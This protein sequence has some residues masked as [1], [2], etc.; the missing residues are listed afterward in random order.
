MLLLNSFRHIKQNLWFE[1]S[2]RC[3]FNAS[4]STKNLL[5][6][7][8]NDCR[9]SS[10]TLSQKLKQSLES[11]ACNGLAC[12]CWR[13]DT[14]ETKERLHLEHEAIKLEKVKHAVLES[15]ASRMSSRERTQYRSEP[16]A[17]N[18]NS[19]GYDYKRFFL[20]ERN[21]NQLQGIYNQLPLV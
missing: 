8:Q 1:L 9:T 21:S 19:I 3:L 12:K 2:R 13:K 17:N 6:F 20:K 7:K 15:N 11:P 16:Q 14:W 10:P 18:N 4:S 5:H